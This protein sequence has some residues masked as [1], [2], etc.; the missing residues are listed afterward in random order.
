MLQDRHGYIW[1]GTQNGLNKY[2][3]YEFEVY[4][5]N[6]LQNVKNGFV[7]KG[8]SAL[9]EDS[10]GNLWVGTRRNGINFREN[11]SDQF[12]NLQSNEPFSSIEGVEI[13]SFFEDKTGNIW[14]STI[15]GGLLKYN[16]STN[17]SKLFTQENNNLKDNH[18]FEVAEDKYGTIWVGTAGTGLNYLLPGNDQF[19]SSNVDIPGDPNMDGYRKTLFLDE[20]Y[21]WIGIE[22]SS[23]YKMEIKSQHYTYFGV[24]T[25]EQNINSSMVRDIHKGLD[26]RLYI[27]TDGGGL[28]VYDENTGKFTKNTYQVGARAGL[29]SNAL[30]CFLEDRTGNLWI[31]TYNGGI[32]VYKVNKTRFSLF[33]PQPGG[34][35]ELEH[36]SV[37]SIYQTIDGKIW[38]GTDGGGLSWLNRENNQFSFSSLKHDPQNPNSL[39]SNIVKTILE[40]S[41]NQLWVGT[42]ASGMSKFNPKAKTFRHFRHDP[43][44]PNSLSGDNVWSIAERNDGKLW[45]GTVGQ[46]V[47]V[48]NPER[49][50]FENFMNDPEN[51]NSLA[52][53]NIMVVFIDQVNKVWVGTVDK[54]LDIYD[55]DTGQF[56]HY[57]YNS[58]DSLSLSS[59]EIRAI[60]QDSRGEIW[61]GTESGGV[62]RWMGDG[63][64]QRITTD[65]GLVANSAMGITED[66]QGN[67]WV[68]SFEGVSIINPEGKV[69]RSFHFHTKQNNNQFNQM[70]ILT[71]EDGQ[72]FF[73]GI[74]GLN[75]IRPEQVKENNTRPAIIFTDFKIFNNSIPSGKLPDGR[76]ILHQSIE[77]AEKVY[78]KYL[79]NSF[80][81]DFT[82]IDFTDPLENQFL[83][84]MDGFDSNWQ[85]ASPGQHSVTYTNLDPGNYT[86]K[87][88]HK[89]T[90]A[91]INVYIK[92][93][94]WER[95]WFK[96][97]GLVLFSG[98]TILGVYLLIRRREENL[99]QENLEAR[100]EI[101]QLRNDKLATEV[102]AKN[103]KLMF[104][105]VQMA[106]KNE[107]LTNIKSELKEKES[108]Q[109][110][111]QLMRMLD[112]E[113]E[114]EDYWKEFN[115]YF[116]QVDQD[117]VKSILDKYPKLT[118]NDLRLCTL[119]RINLST[120]EIASL[121]NVSNRAV[122]QSRYRLKKRLDLGNEEDLLKYISSF[123]TG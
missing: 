121:L 57:R 114:S 86:F 67:I 63:R 23:L 82:A 98:L 47:S 85:T 10:K 22:G 101:L 109:Q 93:P 70:A 4:R 117:F 87:V 77:D 46:G 91:Q 58:G 13:A 24:G 3:G 106:H 45:I 100:S 2:D 14:I 92:P 25:G 9:F 12:N 88:K 75:A 123:N 76:V 84:M 30:F 7:G 71:A 61:I 96:A 21:I 90:E 48:Y 42:F 54:G 64:F 103:S 28:S 69:I 20:E 36:R 53:N 33:T 40:D 56:I 99:K 32:N 111:G 119:L 105:A 59:D 52:E 6:G 115:L 41:N 65:H 44:N 118:Q 81:I 37:L 27:A 89:E 16:P 79:D 94:V 8:V 113:L 102:N 73:G 11:Q 55:D 15:G 116:N 50:S 108:N 31:G 17:S 1:V 110:V 107:I 26:G 72:L 35:A 74:S 104:S 62:N 51:P 97:S 29:N 38:V 39:S 18:V 68:T 60:F 95:L 49:E 112:R 43:G 5:S 83:Y 120:K 80:S 78:L 66:K 34:G 19:S 122:E